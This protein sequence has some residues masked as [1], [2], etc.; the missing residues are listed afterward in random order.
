M[1]VFFEP[2]LNRFI[3][4]VLLGIA[5]LFFSLS[6]RRFVRA[7]RQAGDLSSAQWFVR[8]IRCLLIA[9]TSV[10]WAAGFFWSRSWPLIVG[11]II[12][13]QELYEG[14][15]LAAALRAGR[16]IEKGAMH[17]QRSNG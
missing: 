1:D 10:A 3:S 14:A 11:L 15:I 12:L 5:G 8:A 6:I 4:G 17:F 16:K 13:C 2:P 7:Y 9:L